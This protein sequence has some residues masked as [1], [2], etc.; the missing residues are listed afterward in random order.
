MTIKILSG[1]G[2]VQHS[3]MRFS[4]GEIQVRL[5]DFPA[6]HRVTI[7]AHLT[8]SDAVMELLLATD[9]IRR[10]GGTGVLNLVMPYMPY[11]RQDRVCAPG[12]SLSLKVFAQ[13]INAQN[14]NSVK[15]WD[16]HSDTT[17][18]LLDR[19]RSVGQAE[20]VKRIELL[21]EAVLVAP[22]AGAMKKIIEV[23]KEV[24]RP[25]IRADKTRD[26]KTGEITGTVVHGGQHG[27]VPM[28]M[29]DDICDGGRTFI[30]L[31]QA[32]RKMTNRRIEL[33]VTHGIFSRGLDVFENVIDAIYCP[34]VFP[35]VPDHSILKRI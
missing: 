19:S 32:L 13:L 2:I 14:Y 18:A 11:A 9:A 17:L 8:D 22:D 35:N 34:N 31:A 29:V 3:T 27:D 33:Y 24:G 12:E 26:P 15:V 16:A 20:F 28:L 6:H 4:G 1:G 30:E 10:Q 5:A 21:P 23:S 7:E 25:F